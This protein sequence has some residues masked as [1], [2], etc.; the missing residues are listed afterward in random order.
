M[1]LPVV[2]VKNC[3][4]SCTENAKSVRVEAI[5]V[6]LSAGV[7][8]ISIQ[9]KGVVLLRVTRI[10]RLAGGHVR[11]VAQMLVGGAINRQRSERL[12]ELFSAPITMTT[13]TRIDNVSSQH[14]IET[15]SGRA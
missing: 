15:C 9:T 3:N 6:M 2:C 7:A 4:K 13:M 8:V 12:D 14:V 1:K 10:R 5:D 11:A